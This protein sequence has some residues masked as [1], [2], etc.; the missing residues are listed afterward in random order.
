MVETDHAAI[1]NGLEN[2]RKYFYGESQGRVQ[3]EKNNA[4]LT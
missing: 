3:P 1:A 2:F 4:V